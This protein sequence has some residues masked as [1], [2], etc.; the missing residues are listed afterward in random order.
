MYTCVEVNINFEESTAVRVKKI[1]RFLWLAVLIN[2]TSIVIDER[3]PRYKCVCYATTCRNSLSSH[4]PLLFY[5]FSFLL[6]RKQ[7]KNKMHSSTRTY[8]ARTHTNA[9]SIHRFCGN[10][11]FISSTIARLTFCYLSSNQNPTQIPYSQTCT[12]TH[13]YTSTQRG[14]LFMTFLYTNF[15][16]SIAWKQLQQL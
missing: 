11:C 7:K 13:T 5:L 10:V 16:A 15:C 6:N 2:K 14:W 8:K 3:R 9:R 12:H 1:K 4:Y